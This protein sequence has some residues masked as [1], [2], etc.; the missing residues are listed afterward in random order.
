MSP[1]G[2]AFTVALQAVKLPAGVRYK[3]AVYGST[4]GRYG[5]LVTATVDTEDKELPSDPEELLSRMLSLA[6]HLVYHA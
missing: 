3:A 5:S 2:G 6:S 1:S 4:A